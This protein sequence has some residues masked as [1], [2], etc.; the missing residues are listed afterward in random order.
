MV[1][2]HMK[3]AQLGKMTV[4]N[5]NAPVVGAP[6]VSQEPEARISGEEQESTRTADVQEDETSKK[7]GIDL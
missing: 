3:A 1:N 2:D 4:L 6:M 7:G 5:R